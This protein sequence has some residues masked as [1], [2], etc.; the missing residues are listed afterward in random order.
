MNVE[1]GAEAALFPEKEYIKGI[2]VAMHTKPHHTIPY[3]IMQYLPYHTMQ[4]CTFHTIPYHTIPYHTILNKF[5]PG[6]CGDIFLTCVILGSC[7][8][9]PCSPHSFGSGQS[10]LCYQSLFQALLILLVKAVCTVRDHFSLR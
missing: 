9:L 1:I 2:F 10:H 7:S 3:H 5:I 8:V 4:F 6:H